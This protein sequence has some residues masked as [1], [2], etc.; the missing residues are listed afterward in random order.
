MV[1]KDDYLEVK[2]YSGGIYPGKAQQI[3]DQGVKGV[4]SGGKIS[5]N[6]KKIF[7]DSGIWHRDNVEPGDLEQESP[8]LEEGE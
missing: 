5:D 8:D 1:D 6:A 2:V 3:V 7:D 4:I